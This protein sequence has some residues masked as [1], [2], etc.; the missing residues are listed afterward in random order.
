[1]DYNFSKS[2]TLLILWFYRWI[3][4]EGGLLMLLPY[5]LKQHHTWKNCKMRIFTVAQVE[6]NSTAMKK[7]LETFLYALRIG[8]EVEII[9]MVAKAFRK[10]SN[11]S[12]LIIFSFAFIY[13]EIRTFLIT[14]MNVL[15][16]WNFV[17]KWLKI[18]NHEIN[19]NLLKECVL[20]LKN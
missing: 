12:P 17:M 4:H 3:I 13:S 8:A 1:M 20:L 16:E 2:L 14:L 10:S 11:M 19:V 6:D 15:F 9:E 18:S 5:L 7:D